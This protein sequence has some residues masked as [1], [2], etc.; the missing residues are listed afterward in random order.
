MVSTSI[1]FSTPAVLFG[2]DSS[3]SMTCT[4]Y[5]HTGPLDAPSNLE[6]SAISESS[7]NL[8]WTGT[9]VPRGVEVIN[10]IQVTNLSS[11]VT[12]EFNTTQDFITF[13]KTGVCSEFSLT[14]MS[15]NEQV[16][17]SPVG[18]TLQN[19]PICKLILIRLV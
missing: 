12:Q 18:S 1:D 11:N 6:F 16:G 13:N 15:S 8:S 5:Q 3:F 10:F 14:V 2:L 7:F 4:L 17:N 19:I 9:S